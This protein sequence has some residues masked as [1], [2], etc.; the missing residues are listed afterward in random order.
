MKVRILPRQPFSYMKKQIIIIHGG[1]TFNTYEE[2]LK[3]LKDWQIDFENYRTRKSDWK[4]GLAEK[5]GSDFEVIMLNMPNKM[6][7]KYFEWKIWFEKFILHFNSEVILIGHSLGG[8]FLAKYLSEN[9]FPKK[10]RATFLI[11]PAYDDKDSDYSMADFIFPENLKRLKEQGGK[12]FIYG[13]A[14]D[15]VVP[16]IDFEKYEKILQDVTMRK[17]IDRGHFN[18]EELPE[19]VEDI[20]NVIANT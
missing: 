13:S 1:D 12:I 11:A 14:D 19:I 4:K 20:R 9:I 18:Q 17:F 10:I 8:T 7:A 2:Y 3:F 5:L 15:P 6:N 16:S